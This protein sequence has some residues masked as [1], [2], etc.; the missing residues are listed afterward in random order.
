MFT[1]HPMRLRIINWLL[2]DLSLVLGLIEDFHHP[3]LA[4]TITCILRNFWSQSF[5]HWD[6]MAPAK[7]NPMVK[8][9]F[10]DKIFPKS[11]PRNDKHIT[12][13][14]KNVYKLD[15]D[16]HMSFISTSPFA[17]FGTQ[18]GHKNLCDPSKL[19]GNYWIA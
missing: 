4:D 2:D 12:R 15:T 17:I 10:V 9:L 18:Q 11:F 5:R 6:W 3:F 7:M 8:H 1:S 16:A 19:L 13:L 14:H